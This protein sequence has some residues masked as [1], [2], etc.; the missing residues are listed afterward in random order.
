[1]ILSGNTLYGTADLGGSFGNGAVFAVNTDGTGFRNLHSLVGGDG[2]Y[3]FAGLILSGNTLYGTG[4]Y[5]GSS[6][7]GTVFAVNTDGTGFTTLHSFTALGQVYYTTSEGANPYAGLIP[8]GNGK[9]RYGTTAN[10]G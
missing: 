2:A 7:N 1:L 4:Q 3:P 10:G 6:G 8:A 9:T 5:S